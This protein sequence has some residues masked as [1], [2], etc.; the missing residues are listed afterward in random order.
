MSEKINF[1]AVMGYSAEEYLAYQALLIKGY[2]EKLT[3]GMSQET[4][5]EETNHETRRVWYND[6]MQCC[7]SMIE[8][9]GVK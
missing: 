9:S 7:D 5:D 3:A 8:H 6:I 2:V 1:A 4:W